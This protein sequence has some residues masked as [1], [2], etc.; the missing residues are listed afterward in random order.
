MVFG[1]AKSAVLGLFMLLAAIVTLVITPREHL[2][3]SV[4]PIDLDAMVPQAFGP[5]RVDPTVLPLIA[6]EEITA[7]SD[8]IYAK[9][10]NRTYIND[11]NERVMLT[12]A[13]GGNQ[14][15]SLRLH[16]PEVCYAVQGFT[17]SSPFD[18]NISVSERTLG[19]KRLVAQNGPRYEP[20]TYWTVIG[21]RVVAGRIQRKLEQL[22][23]GLTGVI[24]DGMLVR[25]SSIGRDETLAFKL[26]DVFIADLYAALGPEA[27]NHIMGEPSL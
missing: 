20:I 1:S 15:D 23:Y 7:V 6:V 13:Y 21:N 8:Q 10:L 19:V 5:W 12:I 3:D 14:S 26:H 16:R 17:V 11:R 9:V 25:V 4:K 18:S 27:M 2:G 22:K 24:P